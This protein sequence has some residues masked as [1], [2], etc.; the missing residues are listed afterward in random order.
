MNCLDRYENYL[1]ELFMKD[2]ERFSERSEAECVSA[3]NQV[4]EKAV[5]SAGS[6]AS[7]K[8]KSA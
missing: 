5:N 1:A 8:S 7:R 2:P 6:I 4:T 3:V